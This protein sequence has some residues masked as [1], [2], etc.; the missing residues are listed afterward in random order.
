MPQ[1]RVNSETGGRTLPAVSRTFHTRKDVRHPPT[2]SCHCNARSDS[3]WARN[4]KGAAR[5]GRPF[6]KPTGKNLPN[7]LQRQLH[8]ARLARADARG[9]AG[10]NGAVSQAHTGARA[11]T[12]VWTARIQ[13]VGQIENLHSELRAQPFGDGRVLKD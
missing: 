5:E 8:V 1:P 10:V 9:I 12:S 4:K 13:A 2:G 3:A 6:F 11:N 7:Q